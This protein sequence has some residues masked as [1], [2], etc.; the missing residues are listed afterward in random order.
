MHSPEAFFRLPFFRSGNKTIK[1]R[2]S[3]CWFSENKT[4]ASIKTK[5]IYYEYN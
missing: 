4:L 5:G 2:Y 1:P 3:L